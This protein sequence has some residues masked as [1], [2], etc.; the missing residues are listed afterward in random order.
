MTVILTVSK[1]DEKQSVL[2]NNILEFNSKA[3]QKLKTDKEEKSNALEK[4]NGFYYGREL[5][6]NDFK[7][8]IFLLNP[9]QGKGHPLDLAMRLKILTRKQMLQRFPIGL[10]Q[11][12]AGNTSENLRNET[13]QI[14]YVW[15]RAKEITKKV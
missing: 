4:I 7:S 9:T 14:M 1:P 11:V 13:I 10:P 15:Y 8:R 6:L 3:R 5:T 12:K 2:L